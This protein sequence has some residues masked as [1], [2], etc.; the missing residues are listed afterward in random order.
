MHKMYLTLFLLI[1]LVII[2]SSLYT[3]ETE[4][5]PLDKKIQIDIPGTWYA[6]AIHDKDAD[7]EFC[8]NTPGEIYFLHDKEYKFSFGRGCILLTIEFSRFQ[9]A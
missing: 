9:A 5:D 1:A 2:N 7:W 6:R 4:K 3:V 8:D